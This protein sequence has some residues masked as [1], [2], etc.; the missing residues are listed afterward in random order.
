MMETPWTPGPWAQDGWSVTAERANI[1]VTQ[2]GGTRA[3][4]QH[5]IDRLIA[6]A[7]EL[8]EVLDRF[9]RCD[10]RDVVEAQ[11]LQAEAG[12]LVD[13]ALGVVSRKGP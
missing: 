8:V 1:C 6:L 4:E 3:G 12:W 10:V 11:A 2:D 5:A 9:E 13:R 7:P